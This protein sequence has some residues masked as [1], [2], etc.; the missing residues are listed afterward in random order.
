MLRIVFFQN[1]S[2]VDSLRTARWTTL[3]HRRIDICRSFSVAMQDAT[4][5]CHSQPHSSIEQ[6][7]AQSTLNGCAKTNRAGANLINYAGNNLQSII[8]NCDVLLQLQLFLSYY[9]LHLFIHSIYLFIYLSIMLFPTFTIF[10]LLSLL[11][12]YFTCPCS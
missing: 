12:A 11:V 2:Y 6:E 10:Q 3:Q 4:T 5:S 8:F 7:H 9:V 1:N